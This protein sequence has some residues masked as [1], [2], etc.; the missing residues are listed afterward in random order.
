MLNSLA[1]LVLI[2]PIFFTVSAS[3]QYGSQTAPVSDQLTKT[4]FGWMIPSGSVFRLDKDIELS[5]VKEVAEIVTGSGADRQKI[6]QVTEYRLS[7]FFRNGSQI[8]PLFGQLFNSGRKRCD[9]KINVPFN[10]EH[11]F[12]SGFSVPDPTSLSTSE[13]IHLKGPINFYVGDT[14]YLPHFADDDF[15]ALDFDVKIE[16]SNQSNP[17]KF[18]GSI[19]CKGG[20]ITGFWAPRIASISNNFGSMSLYLPQNQNLQAVETNTNACFEL[21]SLRYLFSSDPKYK[22]GDTIS[23]SRLTTGEVIAYIRGD[24]YSTSKVITQTYR[25]SGDRPCSS[26]QQ[27]KIDNK[28]CEVLSK[29]N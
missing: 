1:K 8:W 19:H 13:N 5:V 25:C 7:A 27:F 28:V 21:D 26:L 18:K 24:M 9:L 17:Q 14:S 20:I 11:D 29:K 12:V 10:R 15:Q 3:A 22:F 2:G 4:N 16:S 23:F 6:Q